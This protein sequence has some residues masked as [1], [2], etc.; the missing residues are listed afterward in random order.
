MSYFLNKYFTFKS[1]SQSWK[2]IA[3]FVINIAV[4]YLIAYGLA[5]P[6]VGV[7]FSGLSE[8]ASDNV[9][10]PGNNKKSLTSLSRPDIIFERSKDSRRPMRRLAENWEHGF[11]KFDVQPGRQIPYQAAPSF[12]ERCLQAFRG[13]S[14]G[15]SPAEDG[16]TFDSFLPPC[17]W[18]RRFIFGREDTFG[19]ET[20]SNAERKDP[21]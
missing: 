11:V 10:T 17:P 5:Q 8:T 1:R 6:L 3:R 20:R 18:I 9:A 15:G 16:S 14:G 21:Q 19:G 4:C 13:A 7:M 2:E 12:M